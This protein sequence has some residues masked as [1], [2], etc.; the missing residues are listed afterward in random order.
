MIWT[1]AQRAPV[2][3]QFAQSFAAANGIS[4]SVQ[5]VA[6][7]LQSAYVT[8]T[9]AGKGPDI[10][11]GATDWI[12]NLVQ[13]GAISPLPLTA[14]QKGSFQTTALNAVTYNGQVYGVPYATENLA[15]ITNT[16]EAAANPAT[17]ETMVAD[18]QAAVKAGKAS[19]AL[20]MQIGQQGD[21]YTA[22]PLLGSAGGFIFG[23]KADG[24]YDPSQV[25]VDNAG[26]K[27]FAAQLA[28]YGE[29]GQ[30]V[31]KRSIDANNAVSL[32][33]SGKTPY[34]ISGPWA[35][36]QIRK[37]NLK[38]SIS[39]VPGF[40]GMGPSQPFVGVQAFYVSA[41][42]KNTAIAQEFTLN[43]LTKKDVEE[44]L[45]KVDPRAPA[46]TDAYNDVSKTDPDIAAFQAAA[47]HGVVLPQIPAM[48]AV[49]G[50]LG[51]AEAAIVGGA[52]PNTSM[53]DA[54]TQIKAAIAKG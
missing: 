15:L 43:Y 40:A 2:L 35:L 13:N 50:P 27:A 25:G 30:N 33:T 19:E 38:Y 28:K 41:K 48:S 37:A 45:Y 44:A 17:F 12:G 36:D 32:F 11:V 49:W 53:A 47:A 42:A 14:A 26:S 3:Q 21:P 24:S 18:G 20:A 22:Q 52:D 31:F 51:I 7:D 16:A 10:V 5:P 34:L 9:A 23:T 54:A 6:T 4:V 29:K 39:A 8:A 1:D 46:L